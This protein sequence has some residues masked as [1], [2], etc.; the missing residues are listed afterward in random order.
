MK[1]GLLQRASKNWEEIKLVNVP[2]KDEPFTECHNDL[3][4]SVLQLD[5]SKSL[6]N[7]ETTLVATKQQQN[8]QQQQQ[9][10]KVQSMI[11]VRKDYSYKYL[12]NSKMMTPVSVATANCAPSSS[13]ISSQYNYLDISQNISQSQSFASVQQ[14]QQTTIIKKEMN[15]SSNTKPLLLKRQQKPLK[16]T[17]KP[18]EVSKR[19]IKPNISILERHDYDCRPKIIKLEKNCEEL[20]EIDY[21]Y[22]KNTLCA[23][24]KIQ[25]KEIKSSSNTEN[26][27][28]NNVPITD[29]SDI[30]IEK[31][32]TRKE[33]CERD[34]LKVIVAQEENSSPVTVKQEY[35]DYS[36]PT[37]SQESIKQLRQPTLSTES[38][39]SQNINK[40]NNK[41]NIIFQL[42][43]NTKSL[44]KNI[45]LHR[46]TPKKMVQKITIKEANNNSTTK[47]Q[48]DCETTLVPE[49]KILCTIETQTEELKK[50]VMNMSITNPLKDEITE[51]LFFENDIMISLQSNTISFFSIDRLSLL[52]KKGETDFQLIDRISRRVHDIQVD[53]D[54]KFQRLCYNDR[55]ILPIYVEMRAKQKQLD[56]PQINCPIAFLY[57]N[58]YYI[59]Q[60][61]AK[62]SSVHLDT[63]K[64]I[65]D[66]I[67][68]TTVP[69][70]SYFIMSWHENSPDKKA[71]MSGI[72]KYKLTPNLDLAKLA[73]IRPFPKLDYR[74]K[75]MYCGKDL[76]LFTIGDTQVS[77]FNYESGDLLMSFDLMKFYGINLTSFTYEGSYL[78]LVYL[79]DIDDD[80]TVRKLMVIGVHK[81]DTN[82][83][84]VI[85][86]I[87]VKIGRYEKILSRTITSTNH[88]IVTFSNG[89]SILM[90]L[91]NFQDVHVKCSPKSSMLVANNDYMIATSSDNINNV[92]LCHFTEYFLND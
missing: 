54:N 87:P 40:I 8:Q 53:C 57:C 78:F 66:D 47:I 64:S 50:F 33:Y 85:Q 82:S 90:Y 73:S 23:I 75:Q 84:K 5:S 3:R 49:N 55:N 51:H 44:R 19:S 69:N 7:N 48:S 60:N 1:K 18:K 39:D 26:L 38:K 71:S 45:I 70:S 31:K 27:T 32:T 11:A 21:D 25:M 35:C 56:D 34:K 88:L 28:Y 86:S 62:F 81:Y 52:L 24:D 83:F 29:C 6:D 30:K 20:R 37:T 74:I 68:Y 43:D 59:D 80:F 12:S 67:K 22:E 42:N 9:H 91:N 61:H 36:T 17:F 72:V 4:K 92:A 89:S 46:R 65:V 10:R 2:I 16:I 14:Q 41:I 15:C 77:I 63:V 79:A 58:I 76:Q 13:S